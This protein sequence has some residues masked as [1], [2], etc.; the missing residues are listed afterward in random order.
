M[1]ATPGRLLV[2]VMRQAGSIVVLA[3]PLGWLAAYAARQSIQKLLFGVSADD[4]WTYAAASLIVALVGC[5]AAIG[6]ALRAARIDPLAA[7]RHD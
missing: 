7:L 4:P 2:Q 6:P 1:G 5:L 3:I